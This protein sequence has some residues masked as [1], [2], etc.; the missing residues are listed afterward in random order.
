ML[1]AGPTPARRSTT[2]PS[3]FR[4]EVDEPPTWSWR[5]CPALPQETF[6]VDI[7][8][9]TKWSKLDTVVD[10]RLA[11]TRCSTGV[12]TE[13][14]YVTRLLRRRLHDEPAAGGRDRTARRGSRYALRRRAARARARRSC[15][16][17]RAAPVLLEER[18][19]GARPGAARSQDEPGFWEG[20]GYHNSRRP[21]ARAALL[22]RLTLARRPRGA[23]APIVASHG[24][25]VARRARRSMLDVPGWPGHRAG[26]HVDVRLTAED[27]YQAAAHLLDRLGT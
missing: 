11:S 7:H 27:G 15:P 1:S 19:V 17:A 12:D 26:Q 20:D 22:G 3:R 23:V 2:G 21:M 25:G 10:G 16:A 9:V 13:A 5:G 6:T 18:Q 14:E 24:R 8:C 4:G